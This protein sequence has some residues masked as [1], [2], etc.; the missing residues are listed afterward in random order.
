M[1]QGGRVGRARRQTGPAAFINTTSLSWIKTHSYDLRITNKH[2][3]DPPRIPDVMIDVH[4]HL[5]ACVLKKD[6]SSAGV[7]TVRTLYPSSDVDYLTGV[8]VGVRNGIALDG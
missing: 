7:T 4:L 2:V 3:L 8:W 1:L 6:G 5:P